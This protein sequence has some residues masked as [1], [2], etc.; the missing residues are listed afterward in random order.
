MCLDGGSPRQISKQ[1]TIRHAEW[2]MLLQCHLSFHESS[3]EDRR[4]QRENLC[5]LK[6]SMVKCQECGLFV[7]V[8]I[9]MPH[10]VI[11]QPRVWEGQYIHPHTDHHTAVSSSPLTA[12]P[13]SVLKY[14]LTLL[15]LRP[16]LSVI[17]F[18]PSAELSICP[19]P[20][21]ILLSH[22]L[23]QVSLT[24]S[25]VTL[26]AL[27]LSLIS[28]LNIPPFTFTVSELLK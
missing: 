14:C 13:P 4:R 7:A 20:V 18:H 16:I 6:L 3:E 8:V 11:R 21:V 10:D 12:S 9:F 2:D 28:M 27:S 24:R 1:R 22:S 25:H 5:S 26:F 17:S 15:A 23:S 19:F